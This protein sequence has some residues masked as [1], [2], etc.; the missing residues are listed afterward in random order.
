MDRGQLAYL[1]AI[2]KINCLYCSYANGLLAYISEIASRTE[3]YWC[4]IKHSRRVLAAHGR[5]RKFAD[6]GDAEG[7]HAE[8]GALRQELLE[9]RERD[10]DFR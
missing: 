2:E 9:Q 4:P 6:Y 8:L 5:Y 1:N 3:Q 10:R 7:Y